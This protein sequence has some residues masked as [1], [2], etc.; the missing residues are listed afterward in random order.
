MQA[1]HIQTQEQDRPLVWAET[2][3]PVP[4]P[5]QVLV[6]VHAASVNRADLA[7]R[8]GS[9][10]PPPGASEILGLDM[11]GRIL[12]VGEDVS[13]WQAGD[14]V[15]A[16]LP[17]GGYAE[18][19]VVPYQML[20]PV[21]KDWSYVQ[22]AALPEVFLTAFVNIFMEAD[23]Q[24]G[25][26]VLVHGGASGVGSAA[27]QLVREAGGR[28]IVTAGTPEKVARC[29]EMGADL[30]IHYKQEDFVQRVQDFTDGQGVDVILDM[31]GADYLERNLKLLKL[32]G[33]LVF[34]A[35]LSGSRAE[36]N[37]GT[38]MRRRLRMIGSVLRSR[39]LEEKI[40][41]K[42]RFMHRFWPLL[43]DGTI[44]PL[45]DAVFP[46]QQANEAHRRMAAYQN[47]GKIVLSIK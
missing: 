42:Q 19:A 5:D 23:F 10:P 47:I 31:V 12:Q 22:A 35:T 13:E 20:M 34:I 24:K 18:L 26:T 17:G 46:I 32:K 15:C 16:L 44:Q 1:I 27:I 36:V 39:A 2:R 28:I 3:D 7:Q 11:A 43:E 21:P 41:I 25:E 45:I 30:A 9:Y 6:E 33:R 8:A 14:R 40:D 37:L 38:L 29:R 4:G